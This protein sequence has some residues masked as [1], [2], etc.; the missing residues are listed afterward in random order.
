MLFSRHDCFSW[1]L[2]AQNHTHTSR[3]DKTVVLKVDSFRLRIQTIYPDM[4]FTFIQNTKYIVCVVYLLIPNRM[5]QRHLSAIK[6]FFTP[7]SHHHHR[8]VLWSYKYGGDLE[9]TSSCDSKIYQPKTDYFPSGVEDQS[10]AKTPMSID[11]MS[12]LRRLFIATLK[13]MHFN[14]FI[15]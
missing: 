4:F 15:L 11:I 14:I 3:N 2:C 1:V 6:Q 9:K 13:A 5:P 10:R 12:T 8:A 7:K